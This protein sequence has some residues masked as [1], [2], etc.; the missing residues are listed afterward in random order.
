MDKTVNQAQLDRTGR[1]PALWPLLLFALLATVFALSS[2]AQ[3]E[4]TLTQTSTAPYKASPVLEMDPE[5]YEPYLHQMLEAKS[6]END[7]DGVYLLVLNHPEI[8]LPILEEHLIEA[9]GGASGIEDDTH[10]QSVLDAISYS[11]HVHAIDTI[12]RLSTLDEKLLPRQVERLLD[13]A[14]DRDNGAYDLAYHAISQA[15]EQAGQVAM[16]WVRI[17]T[18]TAKQFRKLAEVVW[19]ESGIAEGEVRQIMEDPVLERTYGSNLPPLLVMEFTKMGEEE[20]P[21]Y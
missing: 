5:D 13:Y 20:E 18:R 9:F 6:L 15:E 10:V 8:V 17:N 16:D 7:P 14:Q 11:G 12:T 19:E 4:F 1:G 21:R 2:L 3:Q